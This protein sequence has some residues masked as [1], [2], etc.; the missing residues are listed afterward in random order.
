MMCAVYIVGFISTAE[1]PTT[2]DER[3][4]A[5]QISAFPL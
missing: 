3:I 5:K 2:S 4:S 1:K